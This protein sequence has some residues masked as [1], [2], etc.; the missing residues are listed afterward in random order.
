MVPQIL[1][2]NL[3]YQFVFICQSFNTELRLYFHL[4][5]GLLTGL[6]QDLPSKATPT[7]PHTRFPNWLPEGRVGT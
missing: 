7:K 4:N 6:L 1:Y 2:L 3:K 5:T